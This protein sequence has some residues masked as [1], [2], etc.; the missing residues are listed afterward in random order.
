M[1]TVQELGGQ[2]IPFQGDKGNDNFKSYITTARK[3]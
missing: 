1:E 2:G 3:I